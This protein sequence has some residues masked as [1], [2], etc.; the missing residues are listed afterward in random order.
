MPQLVPRP[1]ARTPVELEPVNDQ[2]RSV[3]RSSVC[4]GEAISQ[5]K[6]AAIFQ[7]T[8]NKIGESE[9]RAAKGV[10]V[11]LAKSRLEKAFRARDPCCS[12]V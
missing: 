6:S 9:A 10:K 4:T 5:A 8:S 3:P 1:P 12:G 11:R 7:K 2:T